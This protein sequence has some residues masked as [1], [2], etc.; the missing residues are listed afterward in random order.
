MD[1]K[2]SFILFMTLITVLSIEKITIA[3][4]ELTQENLSK[5]CD[6][7][8]E[9]QKINFYDYSNSMDIFNE[10]GYQVKGKTEDEKISFFCR[11]L[12]LV[13]TEE[14]E[15]A[16]ELNCENLILENDKF[17]KSERL[18][19]NEEFYQKKMMSEIEIFADENNLD[20]DKNDFGSLDNFR[21]EG[22]YLKINNSSKNEL[23]AKAAKIEEIFKKFFELKSK[24]GIEEENI[25]KEDVKISV[26]RI[27][28]KIDLKNKISEEK[29]DYIILKYELLKDI[30]DVLEKIENLTFND[31]FSK[32]VFEL[33]KSKLFNSKNFNL[34]SL[35]D[36]LFK[37]Y[38]EKNFLTE[39]IDDFN[40]D[41]PKDLKKV[42]TEKISVM[43]TGESFDLTFKFKEMTDITSILEKIA[44]NDVT[45]ILKTLKLTFT[46]KKTVSNNFIGE[47]KKL[48]TDFLE[49][50]IEKFDAMKEVHK[51]LKAS[52]LQKLKEDE[53]FRNNLKEMVKISNLKT[54]GYLY[55]KND[56]E[57]NP[58]LE[59][60]I[61]NPNI[62]LP[63]SKEM[64]IFKN[65]KYLK[66]DNEVYKFLCGDLRRT[67][68]RII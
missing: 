38:K 28:S 14:R 50:N 22:N 7:K 65:I 5:L 3:D 30:D 15:K 49:K 21:V 25:E 51:I 4:K 9:I 57:G 36:S 63:D 54:E 16:G 52:I 62:D 60:K 37:K 8:I 20:I 64:F 6:S 56:Y 59:V 27:K 19:N 18:E 10:K 43:D 26:T 32:T 13:F 46:V 24:Y 2:T 17:V 55:Y 40:E 11:Y 48:S 35:K 23:E 29:M 31:F 41:V 34:D 58:T 45:A 33:D 68:I 39:S 47:I 42:L 61:P 53:D 12:K 44:D 1:L 66:N 67:Q